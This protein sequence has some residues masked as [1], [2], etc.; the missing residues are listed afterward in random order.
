MAFA[1]FSSFRTRLQ[2]TAREDRLCQRCSDRPDRRRAGEQP[3]QGC[4]LAAEE[5]RQHDRRKE[6]AAR[7]R[8]SRIRSDQAL[9]GFDDVG[10]PQQQLRWQSCRYLHRERPRLRAI[11]DDRSLEDRARAAAEQHRQCGLFAL[12]VAFQRRQQRARGSRFRLELAQLEIRNETGVAALLL[13]HQQVLAQPEG[14]A[15]AFHLRVQR[16]KREP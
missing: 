10:P 11:A 15:R 13:Q 7:K 5:P 6:L 14:A 3:G 8:H 9:F 16:T 1:R 4:T 2:P 12:P